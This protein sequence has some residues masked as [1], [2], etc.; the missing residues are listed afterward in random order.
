MET[1]VTGALADTGKIVNIIEDSTDARWKPEGS[2]ARM[3]TGYHD[4]GQGHKV[5]SATGV[6]SIGYLLPGTPSG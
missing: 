2:S 1:Y 4:L 3:Q 5:P 6:F